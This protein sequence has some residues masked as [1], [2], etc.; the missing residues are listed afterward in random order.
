MYRA[1]KKT[2]QNKQTKENDKKAICEYVAFIMRLSYF[3]G[4]L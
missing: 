3:R 1:K 2:K 4:D